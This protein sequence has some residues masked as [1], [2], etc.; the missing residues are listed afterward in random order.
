MII[1]FCNQIKCSYNSHKF[2]IWNIFQMAN[3]C[4]YWRHYGYAHVNRSFEY[5]NTSSYEEVV[6]DHDE[7]GSS[8]Y[9]N[10]FENS[11]THFQCPRYPSPISDLSDYGLNTGTRQVRAMRSEGSRH[12]LSILMITDSHGNIYPHNSYSNSEVDVVMEEEPT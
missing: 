7:Q 1:V 9:C 3:Y 12:G 11:Y 5:E 2:N 8:L 6:R 4:R 10:N